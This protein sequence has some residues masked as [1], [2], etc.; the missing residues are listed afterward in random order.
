MLKKISLSLFV[1]IFFIAQNLVM[2]QNVGIGAVYFSPDSSA[3]LEVKYTDK[4]ILF[5]R[6]TTV[7]R[8]AINNPANSLIIFNT[9]TNCFEAYVLGAWN[10]M[11][12]P[13]CI[14]PTTPLAITGSTNQCAGLTGQTYSI[15]AVANATSYS[16]AVPS[17]WTINSGQG[18]TSI[19]V[20]V[21][22]EGDDGDITVVAENGCGT[23][24]A[25]TLTITVTTVPNAPVE[26]THTPGEEQIAWGW[27]SSVGASG[28]KWNTA[29][30]YG[31][32][33][34]KTTNTS[35]TETGLT[36]ETPYTRYAWA[37]NTCGNSSAT[38]LSETTTACGGKIEFTTPGSDSWT[39]PAGV[40]NIT[41]K[42]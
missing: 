17:N 41:V 39:V 6:L 25:Q 4:G 7:Q 2:A 12:C 38:T 1:A 30:N 21:G 35:H 8:D 26:G 37:Y 22:G 27:N 34:D 36:C 9:T 24:S 5:P 31:T 23:S 29:N 20:T 28:Y 11:S 42:A 3:G 18:T 15:D 13:G 40:T 32:A 33:T 14:A 10:I 19:T 16:W